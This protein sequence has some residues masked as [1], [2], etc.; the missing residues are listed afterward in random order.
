MKI[1][2]QSHTL[3]NYNE[4]NKGRYKIPGSLCGEDKVRMREMSD[5]L[6]AGRE[7]AAFEMAPPWEK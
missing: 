6:K 7:N 3:Y 5:G 1:I 2:C 4:I